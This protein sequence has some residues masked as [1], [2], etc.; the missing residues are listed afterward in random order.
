MI[1]PIN[2]HTFSAYRQE[3]RLVRAVADSQRLPLSNG[4]ERPTLIS[5]MVHAM[6]YTMN[7]DDVAF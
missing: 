4:T 5:V 2:W 6:A 7:S 3:Q 1:L